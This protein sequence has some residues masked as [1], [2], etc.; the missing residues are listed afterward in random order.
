MDDSLKAVE[1]VQEYLELPILGTIPR[2]ASGGKR[3]KR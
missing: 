2:I 1:D 3:W